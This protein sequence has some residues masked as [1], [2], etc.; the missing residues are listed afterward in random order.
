[1]IIQQILEN[2]HQIDKPSLPACRLVCRTF[3]AITFPLLFYHIPQWLNYE[4]SHRAVLSLAHDICNRPAV[5]WSPWAT[6]PDGPVDPVWM[7]I[8]WKL[9]VKRDVPGSL[10]VVGR[11][12]EGVL[13]AENFAELSGMEEMTENRLRTGQNR[14]LMHRSYS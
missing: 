13:T 8:V 6:A 11:K 14:F 3:D 2:V 9:L 5:M 4:A 12:G 1:E 10:A 7:A